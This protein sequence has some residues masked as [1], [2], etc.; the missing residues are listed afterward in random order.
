MKAIIRPDSLL[1]QYLTL[2]EAGSPGE[3][4]NVMADVQHK[5]LLEA[6]KGFP[7]NFDVWTL[8]GNL[9]DFKPHNRKWL[10]E[11]EDLQDVSGGKPYEDTTFKDKGYAI[12]LGTFGR[13][14]SLQRETV[15][16]D[17]LNAFKKVPA[18][19]GRAAKRTLV[20]K[21]CSFIETNGNAYDGAALFGTRNSLANHSSTALTADTAGIAA[22]QAGFLA[23]ATAKDPDTGEIMG[24]R[25]KYL[26]VAPALAETAQW[27]VNAI[28]I[29]RGATDGP[30]DNPIKKPALAGNIQVVVEPFLTAFPNRWYLF[31]EPSECHAVEVGY[32]NGQKEPELFMQDSRSIRAGGGRDDFGYEYDD[33]S[34]KV[35]WDFGVQLAFYQAAFKGGA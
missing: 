14:F 24:V 25:A 23:I 26:V 20:K 2:K 11:S 22:L 15:L 4:P 35:R 1:G 17:D 6:F 16:N 30:T 12:S 3:F 33:I 10:S 28:Q 5:I 19:M 18:A 27:L 8:E 29:G 21:I 31:A 13:T 9:S 7:S 34:Y 32:Y